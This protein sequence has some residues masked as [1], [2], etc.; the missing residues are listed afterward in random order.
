MLAFDVSWLSPVLIFVG[1]TMHFVSTKSVF[2]Q[3]GRI[4]IGL[5]IILLSLKLLVGSSQIISDADGIRYFLS[6]MQDEVF[7]VVLL[8]GLLTWIAHSSLAIVLM[9]MSI[10]SSGMIPVS[11]AI[12]MVLGA[13]LGV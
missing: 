6:T 9:I 12:F 2:M 8:T 5:G 10:A 3:V 13:N 1:V 7:L 4:A 11:L